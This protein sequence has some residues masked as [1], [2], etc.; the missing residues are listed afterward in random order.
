MFHKYDLNGHAYDD[1]VDTGDNDDDFNINNNN[2]EGP[3][4]AAIQKQQAKK[5][6]RLPKYNISD[7]MRVMVHNYINL[8]GV[9]ANPAKRI[10]TLW[11]KNIVKYHRI[12]TN[13]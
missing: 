8:A 9:Q 7:P 6:A 10:V 1:N 13:K 3:V 11:S 4:I 12:I 2:P 5:T